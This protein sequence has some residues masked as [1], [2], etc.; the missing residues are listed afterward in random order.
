MDS[1]ISCVLQPPRSSVHV[2]MRCPSLAYP[3]ASTAEHEK[4]LWLIYCPHIENAVSLLFCCC[5][6]CCCCFIPPGNETR[7][8]HAGACSFVWF[9]SSLHLF[10]KQRLNI[11]VPLGSQGL[12]VYWGKQPTKQNWLL[13]CF[14]FIFLLI[15]RAS[16]PNVV[17]R[18]SWRTD[19]WCIQQVNTKESTLSPS[20]ESAILLWAVFQKTGI[21]NVYTNL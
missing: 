7:T 2:G 1:W 16:T 14:V 15:T 19:F 18:Q 13:T 4:L 10:L 11:Y 8:F 9:C 17:S 3:Y 5:C 20:K 12:T 6:C 21:Q